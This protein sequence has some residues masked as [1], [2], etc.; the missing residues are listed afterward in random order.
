M[1]DGEGDGDGAEMQAAESGAAAPS[2]RG[3]WA[4][5]FVAVSLVALVAVPAYY[6][7]QVAEVQSRIADVLEPAARHSSNLSLLKSRQMAR[8]EGFLLTGDR[9]TFREPYIAA[10]AEEDSVFRS[11]SVLARDL[12]VEVF[13]RVARLVSESAR[14]D[15]ENQ[16]I[17]D[18]GP[19]EDARVR[20]RR[21]YDELLR[22]TRELNR[23]IESEVE[24]GRR[25]MDN[26]RR[27]LSRLTFGLAL[28]AL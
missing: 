9:A 28:I 26:T 21:R 25:D 22:A 18:S 12:D 13:E 14:W 3:L 27:R 11:L 10:I 7:K 2:R 20:T 15:F 8:M 6:G 17:F 23:A 4:L 16:E 1:E 5:G 19:D 24:G